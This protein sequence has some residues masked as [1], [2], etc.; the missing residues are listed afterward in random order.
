MRPIAVSIL[1]SAILGLFAASAHAKPAYLVHVPVPS[2]TLSSAGGEPTE[3]EPV[4]PTDPIKLVLQHAQ[5]KDAV[6]GRAYSMDFQSLLG[7]TGEGSEAIQSGDITWSLGT[8]TPPPGLDFV[9]SELKGTPTQISAAA[10]FEVVATYKDAK[11]Q[12]VY[13]IK[14]G[15]FRLH[16]TQV[17]AGSF[18]SCAVTTEGGVMCWGNNSLGSLGNNSKTNSAVPVEVQGLASNM[19]YVVLGT[20]HACALT[21]AGG[22]KCWG[23]NREGQ[24][25]IASTE[26]SSLVPVD[27]QGLSSGVAMVAA[28]GDHTCAITTTGG[29]K[30]WGLN[31]DGQLGNNSTAK[32]LVPVDVQGLTSGVATVAAGADHTCAVTTSGGLKCWGGNIAGQLGIN[33]TEPSLIPVDVPG[34]TGGVSSV[35]SGFAFTCAVTSGGALKCW[36]SNNY[37]QLGDNSL[38]TPLSGQRW[39]PVDVVGLASGVKSVTTGGHHA[40]AVTNAGGLK[41]WGFNGSGRLGDGSTLDSGIPLDVSGLASGVSLVDAGI[42]HT[43]A[44]ISSATLKCWGFNRFGQIGNN[45]T[46]ASSVPVD[47]VVP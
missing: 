38:G 35:S 32:S 19:A 33:S 46:D 18:H 3:P 17:S 41:C 23:D 42:N 40:C 6:L 26:A 10:D 9:G 1:A 22:V 25:G 34:L 20:R 2:L 31:S 13:T 12:Q 29:L 16:A 11:G 28:K 39:T 4:E 15:D 8:G 47:V 5:L 45:S 44:V 7:A 37:G 21:T 36:G 27:V 24:L 14:V 30:C 43:C